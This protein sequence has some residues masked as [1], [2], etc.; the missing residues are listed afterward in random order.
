MNTLNNTV[1]FV[2]RAAGRP[3]S[4]VFELSPE[5]L[6]EL[7]P[8]QFLL[9]NNYL[10]MD[11]ALVGRMREENNY[12]EQ[13]N[14]GE[15]MHAYGIG[16]V[17]K[18]N[19]KNVKVGELRFGRVDMQDFTIADN[20]K[21][22]KAIN[23]GLAQASWYLSAV[24]ITGATA[25]FALLDIGQPKKGETV[26]I[27][28]GASSVGRVAAQIAKLMGC[29]VVGI[30]STEQKA[31]ELKHSVDYD[32]VVTYRGKSIDQLSSD[33][34]VACPSGV[35]VYFD[36]TSGDI[37]EAVMENYND[38]AR[39]VVVG[40]VAISHLADTRQDVGRRDNNLLLTKRI[41]KQGFVI[42]DYQDRMK[43][44]FIILAD[45]VKQGKITIKED[46]VNGLENAPDAFFSMLSGTS[47]GKQLVKLAEI[48]D[49]LDPT[50]RAIGRLM[51]ANWFP[52]KMLAKKL[53]CGI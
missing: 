29:K 23:L 31:K 25:Y 52:T 38:F 34:S 2:K 27:S 28:S 14:I 17:T 26:L 45:W 8:G 1:K 21:K 11:P 39:I 4:D 51:L 9:R 20:H 10:S 41:K 44:A 5:A 42:L 40:R 7:K 22:F 43:G 18:S 30:V 50:P 48:D 53:T 3:T 36:N 24:G 15:T 12:A 37:S 16:Q 49:G 33:V 13:V 19:N 32:H 35:D 46:I 47:K 6:P